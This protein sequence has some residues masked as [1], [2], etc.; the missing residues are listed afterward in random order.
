MV[1]SLASLFQ[2]TP[3]RSDVGMTG[4]ITLRGRVLPVG[5][6]REKVVA[7]NRAHLKTLIIPSQNKK[8][9]EEVP[10]NIRSR[11]RFIFVDRIDQVLESALMEVKTP[12]ESPEILLE[13]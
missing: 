4:E 8:D 13:V 3:V 2:N 10:E 9:L 5:G 1:T 12:Q 6:I 11:L 7:A